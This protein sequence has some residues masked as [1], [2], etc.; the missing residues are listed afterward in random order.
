MARLRKNDGSCDAVIEC[1]LTT[2]S[3]RHAALQETY[4]ITWWAGIASSGERF[5]TG[6]TVQGSNPGEGEV[7]RTRPGAHRASCTKGTGSL[8]RG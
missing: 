5:P 7:F 1:Y 4:I 8:S 6:P 2:C 3:D